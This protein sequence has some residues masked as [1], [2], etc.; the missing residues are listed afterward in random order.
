MI[1]NATYSYYKTVVNGVP[2]NASQMD[3]MRCDHRLTPSGSLEDGLR[4][5]VYT[6]TWRR[7]INNSELHRS[8]LNS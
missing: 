2:P 5:S 1:S 8:E 6:P 3:E 4:N 7:R